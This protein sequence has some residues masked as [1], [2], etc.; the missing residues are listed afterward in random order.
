MEKDSEFSHARVN[1]LG[2]GISAINMKGANTIIDNWI[3]RGISRY[4][5]VTGV[6]GI[7]E[8]QKNTDLVKIHND[9]GLT[10]PDGMPTVW[11]GKIYGY[12]EI[13]RVYGPDLMLAVCKSSVEKRYTHFLYGGTLGVVQDLKENLERMF[14]GIQIV[15]LYTPP[16]RTLNS[17]EE[18]EL[19]KQVALS[20]PDLFWVGLSTPK[21]ERF[22]AEYI[23]KLDVKV[24]IGVGAAFDYHTG[25]A[26]NSQ[27]WVKKIGMQWLHR[28][29]QNPKRLWKRYLL[30]NPVFL[31]KF[32]LQL[33]VD[34]KLIKKGKRI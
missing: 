11:A 32:I 17:E 21:Q 19:I 9:S 5:C 1:V 6:H 14:P 31:A 10:V 23:N 12:S 27:D 30:N 25:R 33:I 15:G 29:L 8:S 4:V 7:M 18:H 22:M 24:M 2:V 13:D 3:R 28:L 16:F 34:R 26:K 20:K